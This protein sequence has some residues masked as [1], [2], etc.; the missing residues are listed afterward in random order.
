MLS[1]CKSVRMIRC[2]FKHESRAG[3]GPVVKSTGV[4][5]EDPDPQPSHGSS[6]LSVTGLGTPTPS[7][8]AC[9]SQTDI[10]IKHPDT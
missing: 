10:R 1:W 7:L 3:Y 9:V 8:H 2:T 4:L 6:Q 5:P